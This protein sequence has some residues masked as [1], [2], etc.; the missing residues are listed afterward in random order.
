MQFIS[1]TTDPECPGNPHGELV[2]GVLKI[3][4]KL[5]RHIQRQMN[6]GGRNGVGAWGEGGSVVVFAPGPR[7]KA[8]KYNGWNARFLVRDTKD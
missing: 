1:E 3:T 7:E 5:R 8:E 4:G 2:N 6:R